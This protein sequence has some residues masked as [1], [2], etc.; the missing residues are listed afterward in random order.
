MKVIPDTR[1]VHYIRYL[2]VIVARDELMYV[3]FYM[4]GEWNPPNMRLIYFPFLG[5]VMH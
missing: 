1:R 5:H 4:L 2:L 3:F